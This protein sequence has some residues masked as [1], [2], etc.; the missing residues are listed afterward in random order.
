MR[1]NPEIEKEQ[2]AWFTVAEAAL[3]LGITP[4]AVQL[5][6][7]KGALKRKEVR[8]ERTG[9]MRLLVS[10]PELTR[11]ASLPGA[12]E[13]ARFSHE[14]DFVPRFSR[15]IDEA[16]AV[17]AE[18]FQE[19]TSH[20]KALDEG[21]ERDRR[22]LESLERER[23]RLA[24]ELASAQAA[25]ETER[26]LGKRHE[27]SLHRFIDRQVTVHKEKEEKLLGHV[28]H[29][30]RALGRAEHQILLLKTR[31]PWWK[32]LLSRLNP[33]SSKA[34]PRRRAGKSTSRT[35]NP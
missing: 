34:K 32:R 18:E 26:E 27:M 30:A 25:L 33:F 24:K 3:L 5:R 10:G 9:R 21:L 11:A 6:A 20:L 31:R 12:R 29:L 7:K 1:P 13:K 2:G 22:A 19:L 23:D 17:G 8:S 14:D 15:K 28:S 35:Q 16:P 4:R